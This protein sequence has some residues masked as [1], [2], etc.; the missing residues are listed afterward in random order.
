MD[1]REKMRSWIDKLVQLSREKGVVGM[2]QDMDLL[3]TGASRLGAELARAAQASAAQGTQKA[4]PTK[5]APKKA[6][7]RR[8]RPPSNADTPK[9]KQATQ[10]RSVER[11]GTKAN[12]AQSPKPK[13]PPLS[14]QKQ[15]LRHEIYGQDTS[16]KALRQAAKALTS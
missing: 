2:K 9:P 8:P 11:S 13:E 7:Q 6:P 4:K 3:L 14:L 5:R 1:E 10:A 12:A 16:D 15:Q